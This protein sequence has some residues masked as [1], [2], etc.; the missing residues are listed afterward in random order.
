M[1][2]TKGALLLKKIYSSM[3]SSMTDDTSIRHLYIVEPLS[4]MI[5]IA[6]LNYRNVGTKIS[7][8]NNRISYSD[9]TMLQG[10][11]RWSYGDTRN[12]LHYL[13]N[14]IKK[15]VQWFPPKDCEHAKTIFR[16]AVLGLKR[17]RET[18]KRSNEGHLVCHSLDLYI[19]IINNSLRGKR[20]GTGIEDTSEDDNAICKALRHIWLDSQ[21]EIIGKLLLQIE[22]DRGHTSHYL[23][24]IENIL[25]VIET[26]VNKV[27]TNL[28]AYE[29]EDDGEDV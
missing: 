18:Y 13:L 2:Y 21:I 29:S 26:R 1:S 17:L 19:S 3:S 10:T 12:D 23:N 11:L 7:I 27:V 22:E 9:P 28:H 6:L 20:K 15:A 4:A 16:V 14:P 5:R 24:A 25:I 8:S